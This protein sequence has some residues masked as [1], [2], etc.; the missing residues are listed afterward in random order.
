MKKLNIALL[1]ATLCGTAG[2][3][4]KAGPMLEPIE[5]GWRPYPTIRAFD[6]PGRILRRDASGALYGVG[7]IAVTNSNCGGAEALPAVKRNA[8]FK[9]GDVL[10]TIGVAKEALPLTASAELSRTADYEVESFDGVRECL[11]DGDVD[12]ILGNIADYFEQRNIAVRPDNEYFLIRETLS[13]KRVK[14]TSSKAWLGSLGADAQFRRQLSN[15]AKLEWG[16]GTTY[17]LDKTF[18]QPMRVWYRAE[19]II[20]KPAL[21]AGP[22]QVTVTLAGLADE[23][24]ISEPIPEKP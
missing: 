13:T 23:N 10:E 2:C 3:G 5:T 20:V 4:G 11:D 12:P 22:G 15:K 6:P 7:T 17:S 1:A 24:L 14:F 18:D 21:G 8:K 16:D 9:I 19:R